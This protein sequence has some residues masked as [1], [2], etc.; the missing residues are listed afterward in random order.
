[1]KPASMIKV[2]ITGP[3]TVLPSI[4][5]ELHRLKLL[6]IVDHTKDNNVDIGTALPIASQLSEI[7]IKIRSICSYLDINLKKEPELEKIDVK[8]SEYDPYSLGK[9]SR[10]LYNEVTLKLAKTKETEDKIAER[11]NA[12]P[13]LRI[14]NE[15]QIN[16]ENLSGYKKITCFFGRINAEES[17]ITRS[18]E[19]IT[20][21][22]EIQTAK[23]QKEQ[24]G[25]AI[26]LYVEKTK[27]KEAQ[28]ILSN[29]GF[30][31][32]N[33]PEFVKKG[34]AE[35]NI[36]LIE[37]E[38]EYF[39]KQQEGIKKDLEE[40]SS[41]WE[42]FL[43]FNERLLSREIEKAEAPLRF[44]DFP[45]AFIATGWI[46]EQEF[47]K[48]KVR[49]N[50]A[51]NNLV[52]IDKEEIIKNE[53]TPVKLENKGIVKPFESLLELY[54]IPK[55]R[56]ID[57]TFMTFLTFPLFF[58]FILGDIGYGLTA[59]LMFI[60]LKRKIKTPL[61]DVM[62]IASISSIFFGFMFGEF[63]GEEA[64]L[65]RELPHL[66]SR[67]HDLNTLLMIAIII[68]IIHINL[69][70]IVGFINELHHGFFTAFSEKISWI[71][72]QLGVGLIALYYLSS[73]SGALAL[74]SGI[75][76]AIGS[77]GLIVKAEGIKGALEL[78]AI[79][80]NILS[81]ARLMAVGVA[82][83]Y[84]AVIVNEFAREFFHKGGIYSV[85]AILILFVGHLINIALG[86]LGGFLHSI[87]LHYVEFYSKFYKG[88]GIRYSPFGQDKT[89]EQEPN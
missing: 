79:F 85:F 28:E 81:Y 74:Y 35:Q 16:V 46:P 43:I 13:D 12:I 58:G 83:V 8:K 63:F 65:G 39:K 73:S 48:L 26:A 6:H 29:F 2:S 31:Q 9:V 55:Y 5:D 37:K 40:I 72:L 22:F 88:G 51:A 61:L 87:R 47:G 57:P 3:K 76:L 89:A 18:I 53:N 82:S 45:N 27:E 77:V 69:G 33:L 21:R 60:I 32:I 14:L 1:M 24:K 80:G 52:H 67:A 4:V 41:K 42:N 10:E 54:T 7:L 84:L 23:L 15:I 86:I 78:P 75:I 50:K 11:K 64:I 49:V 25:N 20:K 59:L 66:L 36:Q 38:I 34:S 44:A 62:L 56:E 30:T 68:G 71:L 19:K 17:K 70:L